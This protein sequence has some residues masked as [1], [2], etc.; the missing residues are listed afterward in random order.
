[1]VVTRDAL[2]AARERAEDIDPKASARA[3]DVAYD[4]DEAYGAFLVPFLGDDIR[5]TFPEFDCVPSDAVPPHVLALLIHHL[6][7]SDGSIPTGP[8]ISFADL[9]NGGFYVTAFRGYTAGPIMRRFTGHEAD[10][11]RAVGAVGGQG[12]PGM[13]DR[14][15]RIQALPRVPVALLWWDGDEEFEPR[16][17]ILF[18]IT[19]S[20]HLPTD[21][22]AILG[23]W[24]TSRLERIAGPAIL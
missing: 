13:A 9:P 15:W 11:E 10:L 20:H 21:G 16:V 19:A 17:E 8:W 7:V 23:S 18:D 2:K 24:L 22:C 6:A 3:C 12:L 5:I 4:G 14:A 1:M